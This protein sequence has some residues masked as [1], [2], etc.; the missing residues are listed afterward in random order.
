MPQS[1]ARLAA[2]GMYEKETYFEWRLQDVAGRKASVAHVASLLEQH[3]PIDMIGGICS[4][5]TLAALTLSTLTAT[6]CSGYLNFC[7]G[8]PSVLLSTASAGGGCAP[9]DLRISVPS[10]HLLSR[11]DEVYSYAQ[12]MELPTACDSDAQIIGHAMGHAVPK[13]VDSI[14]VAMT[15]LLLSVRRAGQGAAGRSHGIAGE[16]SV[17]INMPLSDDDGAASDREER[18]GLLAER[19]GRGGASHGREG[20]RPAM[21]ANGDAAAA[22]P[23]DSMSLVRGGMLKTDGA[24]A[25]EAR[26]GHCQYLVVHFTIACHYVQV[27]AVDYSATFAPLTMLTLQDY[28]MCLAIAVASLADGQAAINRSFVYA[29]ILKPI[30]LVYAIHLVRCTVRFS[31]QPLTRATWLLLLPP[32]LLSLSQHLRSAAAV[33]HH[34][35]THGSSSFST[36]GR[37]LGSTPCLSPFVASFASPTS[38]RRGAACTRGRYA[39]RVLVT[40]PEALLGPSRH[41]GT[42]FAPQASIQSFPKALSAI[43]WRNGLAV[44]VGCTR[45]PCFVTGASPTWTPTH[46]SCWPCTSSLR[47]S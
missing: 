39:P 7:A 47:C 17:A 23:Y 20:F 26:R 45:C 12:L 19:K 35:S 33:S 46:R 41:S 29:R 32:P 11:E 13:L 43:L 6:P 22:T 42:R 31:G 44:A 38:S 40:L 34:R 9:P 30:L 8:A 28:A 15:S 3:A 21:A 24:I 4:G 1:F 2:A 5:S 36:F 10:L 16:P 18:G 27:M 25:A 14:E 37:R